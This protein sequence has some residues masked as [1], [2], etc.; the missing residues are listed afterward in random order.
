M[1]ERMSLENEVQ[2]INEEFAE[3]AAADKRAEEEAAVEGAKR[4][5]ETAFFRKNSSTWLNNLFAQLQTSCQA[6]NSTVND[7]HKH[8]RATKDARG[9]IGIDFVDPIYRSMV[10]PSA[11]VNLQQEGFKLIAVYSKG[12]TSKDVE[13][14][15]LTPTESTLEPSI[16]G[17]LLTLEAL[18]KHLM[19]EF[20]T[21]NR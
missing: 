5:K 2:R 6:F 17:S 11:Q 15:Q 20:L 19:T 16:K 12:T 10:P 9:Q 18:A 14:I 13:A 3:R 1:K 7:K 8:L 4:L 21:R